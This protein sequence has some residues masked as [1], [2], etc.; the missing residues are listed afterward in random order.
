[1]QQ[2]KFKS[3]CGHSDAFISAAVVHFDDPSGKWITARGGRHIFIPDSDVTTSGGNE[4]QNDKSAS[5]KTRTAPRPSTDE[6]KSARRERVMGKLPAIHD[7]IPQMRSRVDTDIHKDDAHRD[8]VAAAVTKIM[9]ATTMR[10]GSEK[11]ATKSVRG[12]EKGQDSFGASSLR[13]QHVS[14][15]GDNVRFEFPGKSRKNWSR[16][17]TDPALADAVKHLQTLPGE[18]LMQ[19][20]DSNGQLRPFTEEHARDYLSQFGITPKNLRTYHATVM[21][22]DLLS[23]IGPAKTETAAAKNINQVVKQVSEHLGNTPAMARSSYINPAVL[24][25]YA[26]Q[27]PASDNAVSLSAVESD[28]QPEIDFGKFLEELG[29]A[30]ERGE[31]NGIDP[32]PNDFEHTD[33]D[34]EDGLDATSV[35][36]SKDAPQMVIRRGLL[37]RSGDYPDKEFSM[38]PDELIAA[39]QMFEPVE[40]E[41]E[42]FFTR[43]EKSILD[44]QLGKWISATA[45]EDGELYGEV[46]VPEWL[47]PLWE[48]AGRKVSV[49]WDRA[50]KLPSRLGLVLNPRVPD[51]AVMSAYTAFTASKSKN[52]LDDTARRERFRMKFIDQLAAFF[53]SNG[54][55]PDADLD[56]TPSAC[57]A[58]MKPDVTAAFAQAQKENQDL[59]KALSEEKNKNR[60]VRAHQFADSVQNR[61]LPHERETLI[62]MFCEMEALDESEPREVTFSIAGESKTGSRLDAWKA[63]YLSRPEHNLTNHQLRSEGPGSAEVEAFYTKSETVNPNEPRPI[64]KG[65]AE[66]NRLMSLTPAGMAVLNNG[67]GN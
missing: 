63:G 5:A 28:V 19:Y 65:S 31:I 6:E 64:Q 30:I 41:L 48:K 11:Y 55:D 58:E 52:S 22:S 54:L 13:K 51:A 60:L 45:S 57:P 39:A 25:H 40:N 34:D 42:H 47:D 20:H 46:M 66:Y 15:E 10:V 26:R 8:R 24:E 35:A 21:A 44:G 49:V 4:P 9:D 2:L 1:M 17:I 29:Q 37:F 18:R 27:R 59:K 67:K 56:A 38:T 36:M 53:R 7:A 3:Y 62:S 32:F 50:T 23:K 61:T 16:T 14:V 33:E 12:E 43:G